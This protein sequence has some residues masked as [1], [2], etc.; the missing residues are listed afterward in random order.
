MIDYKIVDTSTV[1]GIEQ[2]ERLQAAGW[3][4]YRSGLFHMVFYRKTETRKAA[5]NGHSDTL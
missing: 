2:A 5:S 4:V 1:E 3:T